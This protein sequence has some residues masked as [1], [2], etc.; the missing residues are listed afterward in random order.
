MCDLYIGW[1]GSH[2]HCQQV[3]SL[4]YQSDF[5]KFN[6]VSTFSGTTGN[7]LQNIILQKLKGMQKE[8]SRGG[9]GGPDPPWKISKL[10]LACDTKVTST[11]LIG[12]QNFQEPLGIPF[13][14]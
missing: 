10:L 8:E 11:S 12:S 4:Q 9:Q 5:N 3:T 2:V 6:W 13:K 14:I 1:D 7:S